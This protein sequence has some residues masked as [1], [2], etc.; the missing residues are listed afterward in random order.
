MPI[1][2]AGPT[3]ASS[4]QIAPGIIVNSDVNASAAIDYS[5][6][7]LAG[8]I[9]NADI[10]ASAAIAE[11]KIGNITSAGKVSGAA[12]TNLSAIPAGAGVIPAANLSG[13][14][15]AKGTADVTVNNTTTE[16]TLISESIAAG[17]LGTANGVL[18]R[19]CI[20]MS[21]SANGARQDIRVKYGS[22]T[23]ATFTYDPAS[24]TSQTGTMDLD[25]LLL[26]GTATNAQDVIARAITPGMSDPSSLSAAI[27]VQ[28]NTCAEDSTQALNLVV[29]AQ[30]EFALASLTTVMKSY[31]VTKF[32]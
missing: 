29:T 1:I 28:T 21:W 15:I 3:I 20:Q 5:K 8:G 22:T 24:P 32:G 31:T 27:Q 19:A 26:A 11:S 2:V 12:L 25:V 14:K 4:A 18:L 10:N 13:V 9:V 23:I 17:L 6:L 16:T 7:N 30:H